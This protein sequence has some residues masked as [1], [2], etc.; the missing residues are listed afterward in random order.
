MCG[1]CTERAALAER[2]SMKS[3]RGT[4]GTDALLL[5]VHLQESDDWRRAL[6]GSPVQDDL[7]VAIVAWC[8]SWSERG[9]G[10]VPAPLRDALG[11][12]LHAR[13]E[14][15]LAA[16]DLPDAW[17]WLRGLEADRPMPLALEAARDELDAYLA[18]WLHVQSGSEP[19]WD[20]A[21]L[22]ERLPRLSL[23]L[24]LLRRDAPDDDRLVTLALSSPGATSPFSAIDLWLQ[25]RAVQAVI[26]HHGIAFVLPMLERWRSGTLLAAVLRNDLG[27]DALHALHR[28][29][30]QRP[31]GGT[32][33]TRDLRT[34]VELA[35]VT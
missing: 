18:G 19:A 6:A 10:N 14:H 30:R 33:G 1:H 25:R 17:M 34:A 28:V 4:T 23:A 31:D 32:E 22:H 15:W 16:L 24:D 12:R 8:R 9:T 27:R 29:L 11:P 2:L 5:P 7:V 13:L 20:E 35:L 21:T 3:T 26:A